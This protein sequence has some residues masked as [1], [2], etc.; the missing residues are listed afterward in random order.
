M[1]NATTKEMRI[2]EIFLEIKGNNFNNLDEFIEILNE[3]ALCIKFMESYHDDFIDLSTKISTNLKYSLN[4]NKKLKNE[5]RELR[6][7]I[8]T[9][10]RENNEYK[11]INEKLNEL[12][13][14]HECEDDPIK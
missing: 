12:L 1:G 5:I 7:Y 11:M 3:K 2:I 4:E 9:L 6:N 13:P 10:K 14:D 8:Q